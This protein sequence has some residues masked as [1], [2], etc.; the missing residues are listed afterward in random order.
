M[1]NI[2]NIYSKIG[3]YESA[4]NASSSSKKTSE[5]EK[6][7]G[8]DSIKNKLDSKA[9]DSAKGGSDSKVKESNQTF[10]S[11]LGIVKSS[12]LGKVVGEPQLSDKAAEYYKELKQKYKNMD[13]ILVSKDQMANVKANA[14]AYG[15]ANKTVVLVDEDKIER[16]ATDESFRKQ[17]EGI[18]DKAANSFQQIKESLSATG[19]NVKNFGMTVN[20]DG[21]AS[22]FAVLE[23]SSKEQSNRIAKKRAEKAAEKKV[24]EKKANKKKTEERLEKAK[25]E[26]SSKIDDKSN[27]K[28]DRK[29]KINDSESE[30]VV[31]KADSLEDLLQK[32]QDTAASFKSDTVMTDQELSVGGSIDFKA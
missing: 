4:Y 17:Y 29:E 30:R 12:N 8:S 32:V 26:R 9:A 22:Y 6:S 21:T 28:N 27:I 20:D 1:N 7:S 13:F 31:V 2:S 11:S 14:A 15:R 3:A 19:A 25:E 23:K 10:T 24:Q 18:I 16:M 5:K